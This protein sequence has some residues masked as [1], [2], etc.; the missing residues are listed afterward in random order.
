MTKPI[1][2]RDDDGK[3]VAAGDRIFFTYGIPPVGVTARVVQRGKSL[4]ALTP[5]HNPTE[6][7]LRSLRRYV[8]N[9]N[10]HNDQAHLRVGGKTA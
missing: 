1:T 9:W 3:L 10:K 6:C 4:I 7:N 5:G 8:G 2:M